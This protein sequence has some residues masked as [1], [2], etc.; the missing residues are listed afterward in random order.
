MPTFELIDLE[1]DTN[2]CISVT[3]NPKSS[4]YGGIAHF[5]YDGG[6]APNNNETGNTQDAPDDGGHKYVYD[7]KYNHRYNNGPNNAKH[8]Y[9]YKYDYNYDYGDEQRDG[10][11][12]PE[13]KAFNFEGGYTPINNR[14]VAP[15]NYNYGNGVTPYNY[16]SAFNYGGE[17]P[18]C[19]EE[20][21]ILPPVG[22]QEEIPPECVE[23]GGIPP[24][25][26]GQGG[27]PP[28]HPGGGQGWIPPQHPGGG[29]ERD[30]SKCWRQGGVPPPLPA[31]GQGGI[32][33]PYTNI[34]CEI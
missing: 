17:P 16:I 4:N 26:G 14:G 13:V 32:E 23:Q 28:P 10:G 21:W 8:K 7:Y 18:E 24:P 6:K 22:G 5:N 15:N 3:K 2:L 29:Q 9:D 25:V 12:T 33:H 31:G 1:S 19:V 20:G 11:R 34:N 30:P 27:I